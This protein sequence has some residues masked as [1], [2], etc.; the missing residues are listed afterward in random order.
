MVNSAGSVYPLV[1]SIDGIERTRDLKMSG[2][3]DLDS[4]GVALPLPYRIGLILV[5]GM[6]S[7]WAEVLALGCPILCVSNSL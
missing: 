6:S 7:T 5:A 4:L 1:V 2:D 3:P